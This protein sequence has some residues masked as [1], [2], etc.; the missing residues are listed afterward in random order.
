MT[1][2]SIGDTTGE[3]LSER[4][5]HLV[6]QTQMNRKSATSQFV[7]RSSGKGPEL[8][9]FLGM[10]FNNG[11]MRHHLEEN[12]EELLSFARTSLPGLCE[13][14]VETMLNGFAEDVK[15]TRRYRAVMV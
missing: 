9:T 5:S 2:I 7:T 11:F 15:N 12:V 10:V 1:F 3:V 4:F 6:A 8:A 14:D 13:E